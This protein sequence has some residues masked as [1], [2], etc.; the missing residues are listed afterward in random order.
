MPWP[1]TLIAV[2][3][4]P[5]MRPH[6]NDFSS[7]VEATRSAA[8]QAGPSTCR[9]A[10][11]LQLVR[12]VAAEAVPHLVLDLA[13]GLM[14]EVQRVLLPRD[15]P[16]PPALAWAPPDGGLRLERAR[17]LLSHPRGGGGG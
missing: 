11:H 15:V 9:W 14:H 1:D 3:E 4:A 5:T 12:G 17:V 10:P 7:S 6:S 16:T 2:Y 8:W 13:E